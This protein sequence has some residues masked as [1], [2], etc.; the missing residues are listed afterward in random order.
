MPRRC[1]PLFLLAA[2]LTSSTALADDEGFVKLF[3]DDGP[4][5]GWIVTEWNDVSKKAPAGVEWTVKD[6]LL[7]A[8][9]KRG[10]WL[11]SEKEYADFILEFEVKLTE[12][13]NSGVA[14]RSPLKG[15][16][17][18]DGMELQIADFRYNMQAKDSELTGGIYRAIAPTKQV[19][20]PTEWNKVRIELKGTALK[21]TINGELIQDVDLSKFD[22][23]IKRHDGSDAVPI[24]DR[25]RRGHIGFQH[26]SRKDE[27]VVYRNVRIKE[28]K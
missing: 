14:L 26:L 9:S 10:T 13:G 20:K 21:A 15:D 19:Y 17:A 18:F 22:Q 2:L 5:K 16:P 11:V 24:K 25:P 8:G 23:V 12:V 1:I 27:P 3:T 7:E 28:L 6:G 4:P